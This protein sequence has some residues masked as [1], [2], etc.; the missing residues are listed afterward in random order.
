MEGNGFA[1]TGFEGKVAAVTGA[2]RMRSIGRAIA[3]DLARAGCDVALTGTGRSPE[4]YPAEEREAGWRDVESVADEIRAMGRRAM[5]STMSINDPAACEQLA[6]D[7]VSE[8]GRVDVLVNAAAAPRGNDHARVIDMEIEAWQRSI[9][10]NLNGA[11]YMCRAFGRRL[12]EGE[13]GGSIVNISSIASKMMREM[14][15]AYSA[16]KVGMNALTSSMAKELGSSGIR[17]NSICP[18][19]ILT[20]RLED[21]PA[22][23][24]PKMIQEIPLGRAGMPEDISAIVV[25]LA[26]DQGAWITGQQWNIDG[27]QVT[28][29]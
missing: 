6:G 12:V 26:S 27:G 13:R 17:V 28:M 25:F 22:D 10:I 19:Y 21:V 5:T 7:V 18:G 9:D 20:S 29:H 15:S 4:S 3:L 11:F 8:L 24:R 1:L 14:R 16:G 2:G 23:V